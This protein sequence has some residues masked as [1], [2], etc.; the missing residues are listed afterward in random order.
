M[1]GY[2]LPVR[3][4][5]MSLCR[6]TINFVAFQ[7]G[8]FAC[9]AGAAHGLPWLGPLL[10][11]PIASWHLANADRPADEL[12]FML[13]ATFLGALFDQLLLAMDLVRFVAIAGWPP[14]LLPPWMVALWLM[15][16]TT[17][18]ISLRWAG[19]RFAVA[20]LLGLAGGP[21]AYWAGAGLGA[22]SL[23]DTPISLTA[24]GLG[25]AVIMPAL[26]RLYTLFGGYAGGCA[27]TITMR[28][29]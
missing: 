5:G 20:A 9:V 15:F 13:M 28:H 8:W 12:R 4:S 7:A 27:S 1:V 16:N 22:F 23:V 2:A 6:T 24:I 17:P 10:A 3:A 21:L 29:V 25:W 11:L 14:T 18:G 26:M 19:G